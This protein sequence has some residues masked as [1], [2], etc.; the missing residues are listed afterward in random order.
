[1]DA[2]SAGEGTLELVVSTKHSTVK[3]EVV[4]CS[5][6]LY[7]VTFVPHEP[8][9]HFVNISFN[10]EDVPGTLSRGEP[11]CREFSE[12]TTQ[13]CVTLVDLFNLFQP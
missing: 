7:D 10:E 9:P 2:S 3:A 11:S 8:T 12:E 1:M 5:R 6:G 4:A 13:S